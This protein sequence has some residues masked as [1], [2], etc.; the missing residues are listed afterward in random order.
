[1]QIKSRT[2]H[3]NASSQSVNARATALI[4]T[5]GIPLLRWIIKEKQEQDVSNKEKEG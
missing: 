5:I 1:M 4:A 2:T 3:A